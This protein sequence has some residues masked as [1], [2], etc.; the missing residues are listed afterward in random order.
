M[1]RT[2]LVRFNPLQGSFAAR[3]AQVFDGTGIPIGVGLDADGGVVA[4]AGNTGILGVIVPGPT[5]LHDT[6]M[7]M[8]E[9]EL[10]EFGG[11]A[12][13]VYTADD[14]TGAIDATPPGAGR[15]RIGHTVTADRLVV[16]VEH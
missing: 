1:A 4:G 15:T 9:G 16:A 13:T 5:A 2:D 7:V 10:V 3:A 11:L 6:L 14:V 12:G 8:R